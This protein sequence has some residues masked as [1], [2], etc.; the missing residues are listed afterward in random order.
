MSPWTALL[1]SLHS[2]LVDELIERHPEPKPTLGLPLRQREFGAP[3]ESLKSLL[4]TQ[5]AIGDNQG[6]ACLALDSACLTELGIQPS[7][8]WEA[9]VKRAAV[10][11]ARRQLRPRFDKSAELGPG[12]KLPPGHLQPQRVIWIP[13]TLKDGRCF[14]G[15]GV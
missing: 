13:F 4:V 9:L 8:L 2:A 3:A 15:I 7:T 12:V 1:E 14:L 11:F 5:V 10:E 6:L